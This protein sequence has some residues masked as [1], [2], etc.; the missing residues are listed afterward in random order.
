MEKTPR[1][2]IMTRASWK[3]TWRGGTMFADLLHKTDAE[4]PLVLASRAINNIVAQPE[5]GV[6]V[7]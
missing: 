6:I 7:Y 3:N 5:I 4:T 2:T 1:P